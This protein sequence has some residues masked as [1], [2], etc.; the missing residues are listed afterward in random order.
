MNNSHKN[1][2]SCHAELVL[3]SELVSA[4]VISMHIGIIRKGKNCHPDEYRDLPN[5][6]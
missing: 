1:N 2:G 5:E 3:A 6:S 4:S